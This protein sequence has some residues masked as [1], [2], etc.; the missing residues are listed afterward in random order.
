M[1]VSKENFPTYATQRLVFNYFPLSN[2]TPLTG[3]YASLFENSYLRSYHHL[4]S[5]VNLGK[6]Y[7]LGSDGEE[8]WGKLIHI[9]DDLGGLNT[10]RLQ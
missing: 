8:K 10:N 2:A 1:Q 7:T 5:Q 6:I 9:H 3:N 4:N